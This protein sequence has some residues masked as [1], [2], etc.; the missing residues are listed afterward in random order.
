MRVAIRLMALSK[1]LSLSAGER[2]EVQA[3]LRKH[4]LPA[5][6]AQRMRLRWLRVLYLQFMQTSDRSLL[7]R[8]MLIH[9]NSQCKSR[10]LS[11]CK[12]GSCVAAVGKAVQETPY[13]LFPPRAV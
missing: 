8:R 12:A 10:G 5:A 1:L 4:D 13:R 11:E 7:P 3:H 9:T 6:V 2:T